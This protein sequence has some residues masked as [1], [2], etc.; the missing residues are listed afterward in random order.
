MTLYTVRAAD[1]GGYNNGTNGYGDR[2]IAAFYQVDTADLSTFNY[3]T[4]ARLQFAIAAGVISKNVFIRLFDDALG[5]RG[6]ELGNTQL[7][8][9][10]LKEDVQNLKYTD[11]DF[12]PG[13]AIP[14]SR[15]LYI[16]V[17]Y[18]QLSWSSDSLALVSNKDP[19]TNPSNT[20][21]MQGD[22]VWY[23]YTAPG[24]T[25]LRIS[26]VVLPY[27]SLDAVGCNQVLA[28]KLPIFNASRSNNDVILSC[29]ISGEIN[30]DHYELE[31]VTDNSNF[32]TVT[33]IKSLNSFG[34]HSYSFIDK[35]AYGNFSM[36]Q[37]RLKQFS[38]NGTVAYSRIISINP[39]PSVTA[40]IFANPFKGA[41]RLQLNLAVATT[42]AVNVYD[43]QGR[44]VAT[45]NVKTYSAA[46][47]S[48]I[49]NSTQKLNSGV[50][51]FE[52]IAGK[53][54]QFYKVIKQ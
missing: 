28:L 7:P 35:N 14:A 40:I 4:D 16:Y 27:L 46:R 23:H 11:I 26:L 8:L 45:E 19:Q 36:L 32:K 51:I 3:V 5:K 25:Y 43:L 47:T 6:V 49:S 48:I 38:N 21:E 9:S 50:Y 33:N 15:K 17:D 53:Q 13:I 52:V 18:S 22:G 2:Q 44:R 1:G 34:E 41:L 39:A 30:M 29:R 54:R 12:V 31:R 37:Y 20:W 42:L 10:A 24:S